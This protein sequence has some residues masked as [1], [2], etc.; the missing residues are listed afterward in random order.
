MT[1]QLVQILV[2]FLKMK[3]VDLWLLLCFFVIDDRISEK[4]SLSVVLVCVTFPLTATLIH[5]DVKVLSRCYPQF[6]EIA[7]LEHF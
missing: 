5:W 6:Q 4:R 3:S 1:D 2:F 7:Y